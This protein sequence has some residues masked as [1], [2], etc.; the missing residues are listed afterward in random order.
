MN[1]RPKVEVNQRLKVEYLGTYSSGS[2]ACPARACVS[3]TTSPPS[4]LIPCSG[5]PSRIRNGCSSILT[6]DINDATLL[7]DLLSYLVWISRQS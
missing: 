4:N 3:P 7:V 1:F 5:K 2:Q 6:Q